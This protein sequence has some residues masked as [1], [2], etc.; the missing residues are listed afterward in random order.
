MKL[1]TPV[2]Q[3]YLKTQRLGRLASISPKGLP[4]IVAIGYV[5][6]ESYLYFCTFTKSKKVRNIRDNNNV[7]II[8]DDS[9]GSAGW[10]Y[11]TV[12]GN[13][14]MIADQ[15]EFRKVRD[16]LCDKYPVYLSGEW[17]INEEIHTLIRIEP[18]KVLSANIE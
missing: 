1:S 11:V 17:T 8:V 6:D 13:G 14:Y 7:A 10:R 12:E 5:N 9:G 15:E 18:K 2:I 4:H 3:N 16:M